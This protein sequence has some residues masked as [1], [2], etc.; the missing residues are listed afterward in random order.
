MNSIPLLVHWLVLA[1]KFEMRIASFYW[2][3]VMQACLA[4]KAKDLDK[5]DPAIQSYVES[6][7]ISCH[8]EDEQ[9]G[10]RRLDMLT[11]DLSDEENL[12]L[13]EEILDQLNLGEMPPKKKSVTQPKLTETR[14]VVAS[15]TSLLESVAAA[16]KESYSTLRRLTRDQYR[17]T[18]AELLGVN[19]I[20]FDP[21][22]T[23]PPEERTHGFINL[24]KSQII[25]DSL[26]QHYLQAAD[27][28][29][30]KAIHF[31]PEPKRQVAIIKPNEFE[32]KTRRARSKIWW[33]LLKEDRVEIG[34]GYPEKY[35]SHPSKYGRSGAPEDG[36]YKIRVKAAGLNR[37]DHPYEAKDIGHDMSEKMQ[38]ALGIAYNQ[39]S[40]I[41]SARDGRRIDT[42]FQLEDNT[43]KV[44]EATV[45][46]DR[47]S[48]PYFNWINGI[49]NPR[50]L[51]NKRIA[52]KYYKDN[53]Q[54]M[55]NLKESERLHLELEGRRH[56][57][58]GDVISDFYQG[59][60]IAIYRVEIDGPIIDEWPPARHRELFGDTTNPAAINVSESLQRFASRAFRRPVAQQEI[61]H[62]VNYA[63]TLEQKG[64]SRINAI[65]Q[66][67]KAILVSP[68]FLYFEEGNNGALDDHQIASRLAYFLWD[69]MP[70]SHLL[71]KA[72]QGQLTN[73]KGRKS[74]AEQM[75]ADDRSEKFIHAFT[76]A[77]L[78]LYKLGSM[79][80]APQ[81]YKRYYSLRLEDA[82]REE[83]RHF[84][85]YFIDNNLPAKQLLTA[86]YS[87]LNENLAT[88]YGIKGVSGPTLRK[89]QL[90]SH[91]RRKG[92][93]GHGSILTL[94]ANGVET[95]PIVRGIWVL[96]AILGTPPSPP[97]PDVEP[98]E[99]DIRGTTTIREQL[100]KH[101]EIETCADCHQKIDPF[102]FP[103][104]F[105]DPI[106]GLRTHYRNRN[107]QP[108]EI[109]AHGQL[110][111]GETFQN[112]HDLIE[113]LST[114]E[115]QFAR[116][117]VVKLLTYAC[118]RELTYQD[119]PAIQKILDNTSTNQYRM[120]DLILE[121]VAS[122]TFVEK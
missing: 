34:H 23:F 17:N 56:K 6:Y 47:G 42:I 60:R 54:L 21:T 4:A 87:F 75:L 7:C 84:V 12:Y 49:G 41:G 40:L 46:M 26:M 9:K 107:N 16:E 108:L 3:M 78:Q 5:I 64:Q 80:P 29:L 24:G 103:L 66:A 20:N 10:D 13:Y 63:T 76:D 51:I 112:E 55:F 19:T 119:E 53:Q 38:L 81:K 83:T 71:N 67:M 25:S 102:G 116:N 37:L 50:Q 122:Q 52:N 11:T 114:R 74:A 33:R 73:T 100:R 22:A 48:V 110:P 31:K 8:G 104:E 117:I 88:H 72:K 57:P 59:P 93:L 97:P 109:D 113:L 69:T 39:R 44:Y 106:G 68:R 1:C 105:F 15:I 99:P 89:T 92:L 36:Y 18:M 118:G 65:K 28:F 58:V 85:K 45:W 43:P 35:I 79:P 121:V 61:S 14:K 94:T 30:D 90:P 96:E 27:A 98:L 111:S 62:Y 115:K 77:W 70:D 95:S 91:T 2:L 101:R 86:H 32:T 82:M 120:R